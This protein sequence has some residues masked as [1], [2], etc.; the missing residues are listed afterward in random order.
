M[1]SKKYF[2]MYTNIQK[3]KPP[4]YFS[5][6]CRCLTREKFTFCHVCFNLALFFMRFDHTTSRFQ[7]SDT[8]RPTY[9]LSFSPLRAD[10]M[11]KH[12]QHGTFFLFST[13][14]LCVAHNISFSF[15][16]VDGKSKKQENT[17][18]KDE[19]MLNKEGRHGNALLLHAKLYSSLHKHHI[20]YQIKAAH[21][22]ICV[23]DRCRFFCCSSG[24]SKRS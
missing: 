16:C 21:A 19:K 4:T 1:M 20:K 22:A 14:T 18:E 23:T 17:R 7:N 5:H 12:S 2:T 11:K 6:G 10:S 9:P 8:P 24:I 15:P 13:Q 3:K